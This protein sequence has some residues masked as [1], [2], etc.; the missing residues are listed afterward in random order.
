MNRQRE[1]RANFLE[2]TVFTVIF[3][4]VLCAFSAKPETSSAAFSRDSFS[5]S[6]HQGALVIDN[7]PVYSFPGSL[8][9]FVP[10]G[11]FNLSGNLYKIFRDNRLFHQQIACQLKKEQWIKLLVLQQFL[12]R[13]Q[14][15]GTD[16]VPA[17]S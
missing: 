17:L 9:P 8:V 12:Y 5:S 15:A 4:L 7:S 16:D 11:D 3:L 1:E 14:A 13:H 10:P 6:L 2:N